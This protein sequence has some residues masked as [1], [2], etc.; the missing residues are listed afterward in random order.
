MVATAMIGGGGK[1]FHMSIIDALYAAFASNQLL[2]GGVG[3]LAFGSAMYV[4]RAVP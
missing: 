2:V 4:L 3:T 1:S